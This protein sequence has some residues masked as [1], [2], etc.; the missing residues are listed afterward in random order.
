MISIIDVE[1]E[2]STLILHG[3]NT[4]VVSATICRLFCRPESDIISNLIPITFFELLIILVYSLL[5]RS[6]QIRN[7]LDLIY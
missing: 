7:C 4:Q 2:Q 5:S 3:L 6:E 1:I